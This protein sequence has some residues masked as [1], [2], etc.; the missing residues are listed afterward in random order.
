MSL[1]SK[2]FGNKSKHTKDTAELIQQNIADGKAVLLDVRSQQERDRG[3]VEGSI[4]IP[5]TELKSLPPGSGE[6]SKLDRSKII[7]C[8]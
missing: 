5:I 6:V 4:F 3:Y 2:L 1:W 8:H 7:Y